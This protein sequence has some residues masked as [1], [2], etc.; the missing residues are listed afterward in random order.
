ME[1]WPAIA[2]AGAP[3]PSAHPATPRRRRRSR[4]P[5]GR[6]LRGFFGCIHYAGARPAEVV[7]LVLVDCALPDA[8]WGELVFAKSTAGIGFIEHSLAEADETP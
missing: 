4:H 7:S 2:V 1:C 8:G 6:H 5:R 3:Q